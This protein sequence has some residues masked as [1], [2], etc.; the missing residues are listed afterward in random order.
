M[1][2]KKFPHFRQK[3]KKK[4]SKFMPHRLKNNGIFLSKLLQNTSF[5]AGTPAALTKLGKLFSAGPVDNAKQKFL[6]FL[7]KKGKKYVQNY[8]NHLGLER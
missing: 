5:F 4:L 1:E 7:L 6:H 8:A 2:K 3:V